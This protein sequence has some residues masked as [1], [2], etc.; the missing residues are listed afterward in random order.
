MAVNRR[1]ISVDAIHFLSELKTQP[2]LRHAAQTGGE[3]RL[4]LILA[5]LCDSY[6]H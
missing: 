3:L 6:E 1:W 4:L 2:T 5:S